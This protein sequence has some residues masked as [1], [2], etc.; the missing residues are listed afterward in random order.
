[1][2]SKRIGCQ[3]YGPALYRALSHD[4]NDNHVDYTHSRELM[5]ESQRKQSFR[6][7]WKE[8]VREGDDKLLSTHHKCSRVIS[9][10]TC[11]IQALAP[12]EWMGFN[13]DQHLENI[14]E[15]PLENVNT[16]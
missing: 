2:L 8:G 7:G 5:C 1:M 12:I 15:D 16:N 13:I 11:K 14:L 9:T 6:S 3:T 4:T 10:I